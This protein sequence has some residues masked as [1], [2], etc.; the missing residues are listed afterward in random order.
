MGKIV[1]LNGEANPCCRRKFA[2]N[3]KHVITMSEA[4]ISVAQNPLYIKKLP[5][6]EYLKECFEYDPETGILRG[7]VRPRSHFDNDHGCAVVNGRWAGKKIGNPYWKRDS[8]GNK[9]R[10][11][12]Q[13]NL[14][15]QW[16]QVHRIIAKLIGWEV[17]GKLVD[18]K[19]GNGLN[20]RQDNLRVASY[21]ENSR[22]C[23][24][25]SDRIHDLPKGVS[26]VK[27]RDG[28]ISGYLAKISVGTFP[29]PELAHEAYCKAAA[30]I[31]GE[32][33]NKG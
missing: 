28:T 20:N 23:K 14:D 5:P 32:F 6:S 7:K 10:Q 21:A 11:Y 25:H 31:H 3:L 15:G 33:H 17:D 24:T 13:L 27:R 26:Y 29:T 30:W 12:L 4:N 16:F 2:P 8:K 1:V 9:T 22:N 18:H 19:D